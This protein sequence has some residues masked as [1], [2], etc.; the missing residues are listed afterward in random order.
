MLKYVS[1]KR[2]LNNLEA[3]AVISNTYISQTTFTG[4]VINNVRFHG[5]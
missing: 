2:K 4:M 3:R 1:S 5:K